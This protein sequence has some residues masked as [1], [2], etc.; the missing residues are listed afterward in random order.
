MILATQNILIS[1]TLYLEFKL[2]AER[3]S[4]LNDELNSKFGS[5]AWVWGAKMK[6]IQTIVKN[7]G[8][9]ARV[10]F[11]EVHVSRIAILNLIESFGFCCIPDLSFLPVF[12]GDDYRWQV[13]K[14]E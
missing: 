1:S 14:K 11:V 3:V 8:F 7:E 2:F 12:S 9:A 13:L 6:R 5:N 10:I 4:E